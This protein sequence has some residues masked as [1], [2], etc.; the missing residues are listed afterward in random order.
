MENDVV[1]GSPGPRLT[2]QCHRDVIWPKDRQ[3]SMDALLKSWACDRAQV[4]HKKAPYAFNKKGQPFAAFNPSLR[5]R[6]RQKYPLLY[7]GKRIKSSLAY[8]RRELITAGEVSSRE[9]TP[10]GSENQ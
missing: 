4:R 9:S 5:S 6:L 8:M 2:R 1:E 7:N 10:E 3:L